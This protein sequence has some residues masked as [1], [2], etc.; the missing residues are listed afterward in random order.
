MKVLQLG[1]SVLPVGAFSF[2]NG[3]ETAVAQGVVKDADSLREFLLTATHQA[4]SADGIALLHAYRA[5]CSMDMKG[6]ITADRA[7]HSRKLAEEPRLMTVR[8]GKKLAQLALRFTSHPI[9][10]QFHDMAHQGQTTG[11]YPVAQGILFAALDLGEEQ[12]FAV[13]HYGV[14]SMI[15]G[16]ALRLMKI[17]YLETQSIL[18]DIN[19]EATTLF[20]RFKKCHLDD[21]ATFAPVMD[22]LA[23]IH[24]Q[25]KVRLFMN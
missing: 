19:A 18:W 10:S 5:T 24:V 21:M 6:V 9:A 8:M 12:A 17:H 20:Q 22:I 15:V 14:A 4:A 11:T 16:A 13:H 7:V 2:S 23:S 1:D 3:L 25:S